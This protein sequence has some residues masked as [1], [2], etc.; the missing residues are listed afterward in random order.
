MH[1]N[2]HFNSLDIPMRSI[3][4]YVFLLGL[5][6]ALTLQ[7]ASAQFA[8][9]VDKIVNTP[10]PGVGCFTARYPD[11]GWTQRSCAWTASDLQKARLPSISE[12]A[13]QPASKTV[14]SGNDWTLSAPN[15][16]KQAVGTFKNMSGVSSVY[17]ET[18]LGHQTPGAF[19]LQ[20]NTNLKEW[21]C[22][23]PT[24]DFDCDAATQFVIERSDSGAT[25]FIEW[26]LDWPG[27]CPNGWSAGLHTRFGSIC[28]KNSDGISV[29]TWNWDIRDVNALTLYGYLARG[30]LKLDG[31]VAIFGDTA[32]TVTG[33]NGIFDMSD[34]WNTVEY[35]IFGAGNG[36]KA[37]LNSGS[38]LGVKVGAWYDSSSS[39]PPLCK[40][41]GFTG[42]QNNLN[43]GPCIVVNSD[44]TKSDSYPY[45]LFTEYLGTP[46]APQVFMP[47]NGAQIP[48]G[49][50]N[51]NG[52]GT[53]NA[54]VK[55]SLDQ[56]QICETNV[57]LVE[58]W[59]CPSVQIT[60]P[61]NHLL[62]VVQ[63]AADGKRS[64]PTYVSFFTPKP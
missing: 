27:D 4:R 1:I 46:E 33:Q 30:P 20:M 47:Q 56:T 34:A 9:W 15:T 39:V 11:E 6:N 17:D 40:E 18:T 16:I 45:I 36:S 22:G 13:T 59:F 7:I 61:G 25:L 48:I 60:T 38:A 31:T 12:Q 49:T 14:G 3:L 44:P 54:T 51:I 32:F 50:L 62:T 63:T 42:E 35:N 41:G 64:P 43:L 5:I 29:N 57:S 2:N 53:S 26:L 19:S 58:V 8:S 55:A 52:G 24:G 23:G 21:P 10:P 37:V 28:Y